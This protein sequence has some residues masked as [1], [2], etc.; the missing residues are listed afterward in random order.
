MLPTRQPM[1]GVIVATSIFSGLKACFA[2]LR[3]QNMR[4][5]HPVAL[6]HYIWG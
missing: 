4:L 6:E 3:E 2:S 1:D 5:Q